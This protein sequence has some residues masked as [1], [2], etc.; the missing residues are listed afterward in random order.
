MDEMIN[1]YKVTYTLYTHLH[2]STPQHPLIYTNYTL[3]QSQMSSGGGKGGK[4]KAKTSSET[5]VLTTRSS[6]AGLQVCYI[7]LHTFVL[8]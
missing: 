4:G 7:H 3:Y 5:K 2:T 6:K 1:N 8:Y